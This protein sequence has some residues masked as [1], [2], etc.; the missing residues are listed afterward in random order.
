MFAVFELETIKKEGSERERKLAHE[1]F[2]MRALI[3]DSVDVLSGYIEEYPQLAKLREDLLITLTAGY[4][5]HA[6]D[7][8]VLFL[9]ED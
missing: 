2:M 6:H 8:A 5:D 9:K 7:P 3:A 1:I 4:K